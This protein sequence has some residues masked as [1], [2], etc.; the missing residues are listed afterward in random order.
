[1]LA[2]VGEPVDA[3][4]NGGFSGDIRLH[5]ISCLRGARALLASLLF[6]LKARDVA[7][8]PGPE[9]TC[10]DVEGWLKGDPEVRQTLVQT[11]RAKANDPDSRAA[12]IQNMQHYAEWNAVLGR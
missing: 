5:A 6:P 11:I 2:T 9:Y 7:P 12:L 8:K 4:A 1:M 10:A 3:I